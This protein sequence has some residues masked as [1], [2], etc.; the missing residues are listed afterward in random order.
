MVTIPQVN[1]VSVCYS[2]YAVSVCSGE[3]S[4]ADIYGHHVPP[5]RCLY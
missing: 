3:H 1:Q 5:S 2:K 4:N